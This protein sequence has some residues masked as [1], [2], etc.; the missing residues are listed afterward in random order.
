MEIA[1]AATH[2]A[3]HLNSPAIERND[4][5]YPVA[6]SHKRRQLESALFRRS[7]GRPHLEVHHRRHSEDGG[8]HSAKKSRVA[9]LQNR[10]SLSRPVPDTG[11]NAPVRQWKAFSYHDGAIVRPNSGSH[12]RGGA[13]HSFGGVDADVGE[14]E[15]R[16]N[17]NRSK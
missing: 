2:V 11:M 3:A 17:F 15:L 1:S 10:H 14:V 8:K 16:G 4:H 13:C 7:E 12:T 5:D 6:Q 9:S